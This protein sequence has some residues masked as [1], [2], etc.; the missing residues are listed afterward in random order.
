MRLPTSRLWSFGK[1]YVIIKITGG[2]TEEF[3]NLVAR[4]GIQMWGIRRAAADT[5]LAQ[6]GAGEFRGLR[7]V[8][9]RSRCRVHIVRRRGFVF[10]WRRLWRRRIL[11]AGFVAIILAFYVASQYVWFVKLDGATGE[12]ARAILDVA[13]RS[14]LKVGVHRSTVR[15]EVVARQLLTEVEWLAW[16]GVEIRGTIARIRVVGKDL[17]P[18]G[19]VRPCHLVA[20]QP[21]VIQSVVTMRGVPLV[22]S[23]D[24]VRRGQVLISGVVPEK[25]AALAGVGT[26]A[27]D[28]STQDE[29]HFLAQGGNVYLEARGMVTARV[30]YE[31][32]SKVPLKEVTYKRSGRSHTSLGITVGRVT[33]WPGGQE[34]RG[35][36]LR[37][38]TEAFDTGIRLGDLA[39]LPV[40]LHR[41]VAHELV[42]ETT[43]RTRAEAELE[44]RRRAA[45][46]MRELLPAEYELVNE[47]FV[48]REGGSP[49]EVEGSLV[50]EVLQDVA[51]PAPLSLGEPPPPELQPPPEPR[52]GPAPQGQ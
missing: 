52:S 49:D 10:T 14:G 45:E 42:A 33:W 22:K 43:E 1:G 37:W 20:S 15:P 35:R 36:F 8:A 7:P 17:R 19:E 48:V 44:S 27:P 47:R 41:R 3:L 38:E 18:K 32:T 21:G 11:V 16:T 24:T 31:A 46:K 9:R 6:V 39:A 23:G 34:P 50:Y 2:N 4:F 13:A 51:R 40:T 25:M 26:A 5:L 12:R 28:A 29:G 30:W